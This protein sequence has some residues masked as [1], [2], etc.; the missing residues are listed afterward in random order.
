MILRNVA[1]LLFDDVE[2]LDFAGP[3][4]VFSVASELNEY[5]PFRVMTVA[6]EKRVVV[7]KNGLSL[8]PEHALN[9]NP[10]AEIVVIP[11]GIGSKQAMQDER[12]IQWVQKMAVEAEYVLSVCTGARILAKAGLLDGLPATT[13]HEAL[14]S[15]RELTPQV[16]WRAD[17]DWRETRFVDTGKI[18][19]AGGISA[20]IDMSLYLVGKLLGRDKARATAE[21]MEYDAQGL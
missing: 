9:S 6:P 7:A 1:I 12:V 11:G 8:N 21:Y 18:I 14:E 2:V 19:T 15:V 13:H 17:G 16:E 5:K 4:E 20:G 3:F 10:T